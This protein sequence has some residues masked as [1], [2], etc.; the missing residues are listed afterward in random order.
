MG[1]SN[2]WICPF[3]YLCIQQSLNRM[4]DLKT[5]LNE[6][7]KELRTHLK[8]ES[9]LEEIDKLIEWENKR[10][11]SLIKKLEKEAEDITRLE[12]MSLESIFHK[13]LGS[14]EEQIEKERQEYLQLSLKYDRNFD[15]TTSFGQE[16]PS[17]R[18]G[19]SS[20]SEI[21]F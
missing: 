7:A 18:Y 12:E 5:R 9:R 17:I 10:L 8:V 16:S 15:T 3:F 19:N 20:K 4:K 2:K 13:M 11:A 14:K 21:D 1:K 6:T